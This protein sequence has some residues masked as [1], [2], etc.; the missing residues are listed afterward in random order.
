MFAHEKYLHLLGHCQ[1]EPCNCEVALC[2][3]AILQT[4]A[5]ANTRELKGSHEGYEHV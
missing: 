4:Y 1:G 3:E 2:R 5:G